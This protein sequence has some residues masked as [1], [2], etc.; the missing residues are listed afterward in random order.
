M[1]RFLLPF[2]CLFI[3]FLAQAGGEEVQTDHAV[4]TLKSDVATVQAGKPFWLA[5]NFELADGWHIYWKN[6]GDSGL[7]PTLQWTLPEGFKTEEIHW[8][9]PERI[10]IDGLMN[11]GYEE[12]TTLLIPVI[13]PGKITA[14]TLTFKVKADWLICH[15]V[16]IPESGT[17]ELE[18][19]A[20][21]DAAKPSQDA[22]AIEAALASLPQIKE[23]AG[24][25]E[26]KDGML[27]LHLPADKQPKGLAEA[28]FFSENEGVIDYAA[29]QEWRAEEGVL[30]IAVKRGTAPLPETIRGVL[31]LYSD[32]GEITYT[33]QQLK[34][35]G[36][37]A[38]AALTP[39]EMQETGDT[40][41]K[42]SCAGGICIWQ[43]LLFSFLGGVLLNIMPCV[44]PV[45]S[46]KALAISKKAAA[47]ST[48]AIRNQG[49]AYLAGTVSSFILLA[50]VLIAL[51]QSGAAAGWGFQLQEP[52]F[53]T[54][55]LY[56]FLLLGLSLAG[57]FELPQYFG[58]LGSTKASKDSMSGSFFTGILAVL[59]AT[60]CTVPFMAPALSYAFTQSTLVT[61][62]IMSMMGVG[63]ATP[64]LL[65]S[66]YPP[67]QRR[68]PK[69]GAWM[70]RFKEFMAFPI[71]AT[72][73]WL[74]WVLAQQV[75][76]HGLAVVLI[77]V[78]L[79]P[80]LIWLGKGKSK[81]VQWIF[82]VIALLLSLWSFRALE[83]V[84]E[85]QETVA[86]DPALLSQLREEGKPVFLNATAAW[87]ITCKVNER[88]A[89]S[90][91]KLAALFK[92]RDI[93]FMLADWTNHDEPITR[94][95]REYKHEGVP[96]YVYF[97]PNQGEPVVLPQL[98]T[99]SLVIET[100]EGEKS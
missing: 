39:P 75:N 11:Y 52:I 54:A 41:G 99:E 92:E 15:E 61:L 74:L 24:S 28:Y 17:L 97:P 65:I 3:P 79:L 10:E 8:P 51:K 45:L 1:I 87:C 34:G 56:L 82:V 76:M 47:G 60:P 64:Y 77:L 78:V 40:T 93:T 38:A 32:K 66:F 80:F 7:K 57:M 59:V 49:L 90:S 6:P 13:P 63:L 94:L 44:F 68:L 9:P 5:V 25:W 53:V 71:L 81:P 91:P 21:P 19:K 89:L 88:V 27:M 42:S 23:A 33:R 16:C 100:I 58:G 73:A 30:E 98:L 69:P 22:E 95:L 55:M 31:A 2:F 85:A 50:G 37:A 4:V 48:A 84:T 67:L 35:E 62:A 46:L 29:P 83:P 43:A 96:L 18:L 20:N 36:V 86:Y 26:E 72:A 14:E 12:E 70:Q